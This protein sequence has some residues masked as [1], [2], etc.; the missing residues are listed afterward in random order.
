MCYG[1]HNRHKLQRQ[2]MTKPKKTKCPIC[3]KPTDP[4]FTP[5]CS[6]RCKQVDLHRWMEGV[7]RI[8][9]EEKDGEVEKDD[10]LD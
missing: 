9:T 3:K 6:D 5:F 2:I 7:Y 4:E 1:R 8:P 10:E